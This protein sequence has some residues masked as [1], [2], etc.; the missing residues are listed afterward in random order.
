MRR[1]NRAGRA[2][3]NQART[4]DRVRPAAIAGLI[5]DALA[6]V[7]LPAAD[8]A[9]VAELM[10]EA[11]LTGADAHGVFRL[12]QYVRRLRAGGVNPTPSIQVTKTAPATALVDGDNGMGHLVMARA[13]ETAIELARATGVAWVGARALEPRRLRRRLCGVAARGGHDRDLFRRRQRQPHGD[14]GRRRDAARH[15]SAGGRDPRRRGGA[16]RARHRHH[17]RLL[18]HGEELSPAG[19]SHAGRLDGEPRGRRSAHRSAAERRGPAAADRR[20]TRAAGSRWCWGCSPAR[21]TARRS[22]ATSSTSTTTTRAPA[23]TATSSS[24]SM[25]RA[26]RL[27]LPSPPRSIATCATCAARSVSPASTPSACRAPSAARGATTALRNGVPMPP[28]LIAQLDKLADELGV[29]SLEQR[30]MMLGCWLSARTRSARL[31]LAAGVSR[32]S[33][34]RGAATSTVALPANACASLYCPNPPHKG[35]E[36]GTEWRAATYSPSRCARA[37]R[38]RAACA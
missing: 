13:A 14:V 2:E 33:A 22:V 31:S 11:D 23:T 29:K 18:R 37:R 35:D 21:S 3:M 38:S 25:S 8:A 24:R 16:G 10:T 7:G 9:K 12:P 36:S 6:K 20:P 30:W 15:Q 26:S 32:G 28:E 1:G 34:G 27:S 5:A 4:I 17:G 19:Q